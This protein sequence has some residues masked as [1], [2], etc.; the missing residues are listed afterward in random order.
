MC[1]PSLPSPGATVTGLQHHPPTRL[2]LPLSHAI[3]ESPWSQL[4]GLTNR[5]RSPPRHFP[6]LFSCRSELMPSATPSDAIAAA[7]APSRLSSPVK[8][9]S[10]SPL[11]AASPRISPSYSAS[12]VSKPE[13]RPSHHRCSWRLAAV[14]RLH[15]S[16]PTATPRHAGAARVM[17]SRELLPLPTYWPLCAQPPHRCRARRCCVAPSSQAKS[18]TATGPLSLALLD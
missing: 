15:R 13:L 1:S 10:K 12:R 7:G 3:H 9:S 11:V 16:K 2:F 17:F 6:P 5:S 8:P 18:D 14:E 4:P